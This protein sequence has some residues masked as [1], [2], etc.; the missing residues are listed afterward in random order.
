MGGWVVGN[1][2]IMSISSK[3]SYASNYSELSLAIKW[4]KQYLLIWMGSQPNVEKES[5]GKCIL[6]CIEDIITIEF[7]CKESLNCILRNINSLETLFTKIF[8]TGTYFRNIWFIMGVT[9]A[10]TFYTE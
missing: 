9:Q 7:Y 1:L 3:L 10:S 2:R 5:T 4:S 6:A 8:T